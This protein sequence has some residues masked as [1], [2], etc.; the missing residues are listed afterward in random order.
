MHQERRGTVCIWERVLTIVGPM[1]FILECHRPELHQVRGTVGECLH[2][3]KTFD[4]VCLLQSANSHDLAVFKK[5]PF[6]N[7]LTNVTQAYNIPGT[8]PLSFHN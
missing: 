6:Y 1:D 8:N 5:L 2:Y 4:Y 7:L 3:I